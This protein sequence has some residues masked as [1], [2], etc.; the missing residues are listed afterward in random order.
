MFAYFSL[1]LP[2]KNYPRKATFIYLTDF[3]NQNNLSQLV[4]FPT[5]SR[6]I[7]G[8]KKES[9]LDH[10]YANDTSFVSCVYFKVPTF[11]DHVLVIVEL[12]LK[13][14]LLFIMMSLVCI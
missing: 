2:T 14:F 12:F 13:F 11:G 1:S 3:V 10:V 5:W 4:N 6:T 7:N 9:L 8:I